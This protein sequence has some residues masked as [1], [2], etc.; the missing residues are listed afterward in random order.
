MTP[1]QRYSVANTRTKGKAL[2]LLKLSLYGVRRAVNHTK[3]NLTINTVQYLEHLN[4][5]K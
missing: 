4:D 3:P 5:A 1:S 2:Y